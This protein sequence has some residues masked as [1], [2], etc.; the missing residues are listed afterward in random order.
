MTTKWI[1]ISQLLI[2]FSTETQ[3]LIPTQ[4]VAVNVKAHEGMDTLICYCTTTIDTGGSWS[5]LWPLAL[6]SVVA[7][8]RVESEATPD[9]TFAD[10]LWTWSQVHYNTTFRC[11]CTN[12]SQAL[13]AWLLEISKDLY[14]VGSNN[15][16]NSVWIEFLL[17]LS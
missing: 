14:F 2:Q 10:K 3:W 4:I 7:R 9:L 15:A 5:R 17:Q 12:F 8:S 1:K 11:K 6:L 13:K 16:E